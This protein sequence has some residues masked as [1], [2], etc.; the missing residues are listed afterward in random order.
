MKL[1][2]EDFGGGTTAETA[3]RWEKILSTDRHKFLHPLS[4]SLDN[5]LY[6]AIRDGVPKSRRGDIWLLLA[7]R[8]VASGC[9]INRRCNR[10]HGIT[11]VNY[12]SVDDDGDEPF[13]SKLSLH[14]DPDR[15]L[16][17][18]DGNVHASSSVNFESSYRD[19]LNHLT[20]Q[21]HAILVDLGE[22]LIFSLSLVLPSSC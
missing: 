20:P 6:E 7:E 4:S 5:S 2:Y 8:H 16:S 18:S 1:N 3:S 22:F 17:S 14:H 15:M 21:Q 10:S 11:L 9:R 19:L 13:P 12:R